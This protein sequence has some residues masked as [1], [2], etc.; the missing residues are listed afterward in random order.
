MGTKRF[1]AVG[2]VLPGPR[3]LVAGGFDGS[4]LNTAEVYDPQSNSWSSVAPMGTK[5]F[6]AVGVVLPGP[7]VLVVGGYDGS[8]YL[9]TA[10]EVYD[11][12]SNSWSS[13]APMGTKR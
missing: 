9:S 6:G 1:G 4:S 12:Q 7:R 11:P 10:A 5:R 3:V 8:S 13:V 2:V